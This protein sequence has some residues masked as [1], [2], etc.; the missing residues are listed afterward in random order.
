MSS[1]PT[2][3]ALTAVQLSH[4]FRTR[5]LSPVEVTRATLDHIEAE[6]PKVNAFALLDRESAFEAARQSEQRWARGEPL[7]EVDGIP[8]AVKDLLLA[9]GWPTLRGSLTVDAQLTWEE[10]APAVARLREQGAVLLGKT[11]TAEYGAKGATDT[12]R[13]GITRNP[14]NTAKTPGGSSGG[15]AVA[16]ALGF[17]PIQIATDGGGSIRQPASYTGTVGFKPSFGLV[18]GYP[19]SFRG[20]LFHVGPIARSVEDVALIL[21]AIARPDHR[22]W[23]AQ[24]HDGRDWRLGLEG[25]VEGLRIAFSP[26]L[27]YAQVDPEVAAIIAEAV[28]VFSALGAVVERADPGFADPH[29]IFRG[30]SAAG[31]ARMVGAWP[32]ELRDKIGPELRVFWEDGAQIDLDRYIGLNDERA[33]LGRHLNAFYQDW[34]LLITPTTPVAALNVEDKPARSSFTYPFNLTK[35]PAISVPAGFTSAGLPVG[36]QIVGPR[37]HGDALVLRA[38]RA[39]ERARPF[40]LPN[41]A[42]GDHHA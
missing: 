23:F 2:I 20:S 41:T 28:K 39:F 21:N 24:A 12:L 13:H 37:L 1:P 40:S 35:Q 31:A 17:G 34:D 27:G 6:N 22:D 29:H 3:T 18:P 8:A 42:K 19:S 4:A 38:A 36:L 30:L 5:Q 7:G 11:T 9:K 16:A 15:A 10:D 25:G 26:D 32:P 14:W 33:A